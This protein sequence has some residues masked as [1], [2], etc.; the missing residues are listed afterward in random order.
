MPRTIRKSTIIGIALLLAGLA[1]LI[2]LASSLHAQQP[3][4]QTSPLY[5]QNSKWTNG[6][7]PGFRLTAGSGL[8]LNIGPGTSHCTASGEEYA[9][10]TLAMTAS[11]T[12]YVYLDSTASCVPAKNITGYGAIP[13]PLRLAKVT[14]SGSAITA[15]DDVRSWFAP[16]AAGSLAGPNTFWR[17]PQSSSASFQLIQSKAGITSSS[18]SVSLSYDASVTPGNFLAVFCGAYAGCNT[19][20]SSAGDTFSTGSSGF[21]SAV[22][23]YVCSAA[24]GPT[25]ITETYGLSASSINLVH[26]AEFAGVKPTLCL[27]TGVTN[28]AP[29]FSSGLAT[30]SSSAIT[31][32]DLILAAFCD[33]R[34]G[35]AAWSAGAGYTQVQFNKSSANGNSLISEFLTSVVSTGA[36]QGRANAPAINDIL[37]GAVAAFKLSSVPP[38]QPY[39]GPIAANDLILTAAAPGYV[40]TPVHSSSLAADVGSTTLLTAG[41]SDSLYQ[42]AANL[43]CRAGGT[44]SE[45]LNIAFTDTSNTSQTLT[46]T[47][48]CATLGAASFASIA[49]SVR[50]KSGSSISY[51]TSHSGAQ[52]TYDVSVTILQAST[53]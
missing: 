9:G 38:A 45:T 30:L 34:N 15:I 27:D 41:G 42:L 53:R 24:G 3:Q 32:S 40:G 52:P 48:N 35:N 11:S 36:Q 7:A 49:Q 51:S 10:G 43:T 20:T 2:W 19:P 22:I 21:G 23:Y 44:G 46:A 18:T 31:G 14:T 50:I 13:G 47:A 12:N 8:T 16:G 26:I 25:T 28:V 29:A 39:F 17:G 1:Y 4:T 37:Y 5:S 6:I 33:C